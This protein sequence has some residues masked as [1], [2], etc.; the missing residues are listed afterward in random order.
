L[1]NKILIKQI[2]KIMEANS[3][4]DY[5][6]NLPRVIAPKINF[7]K[8][9][10]KNC[11]VDLATVRTWVWGDRSPRNPEHLEILSKMTGI[12]KEDLFSKRKTLN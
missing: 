4:V 7:C 5:Y 1:K 9:V 11:G 10:S 6:K 12:K 2:K 3:L 8:E